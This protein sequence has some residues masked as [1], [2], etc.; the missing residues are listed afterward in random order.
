MIL[1]PW[2][3]SVSVQIGETARPEHN[4]PAHHT[5]SSRGRLVGLGLILCLEDV[6]VH[7]GFKQLLWMSSLF[8]QAL[9]MPNAWSFAANYH[10]NFRPS[11][12]SFRS[13]TS[14]RCRPR[15]QK[16]QALYVPFRGRLHKLYP[17]ISFDTRPRTPEA[18]HECVSRSGTVRLTCFG[19]RQ[20]HSY[21]F[22]F[23]SVYFSDV[24][25]GWWRS[26]RRAISLRRGKKWF[27]SPTEG[28][29]L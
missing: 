8:V 4:Q 7:I 19:K 23:R 1:S 17:S 25:S 10:S 13:C 11:A 12:D 21:Y 27:A 29:G 22:L 24:D 14:P 9:P 2:R 26:S 16:T 28:L 20:D 5:S 18:S 3:F 6:D 15:Q